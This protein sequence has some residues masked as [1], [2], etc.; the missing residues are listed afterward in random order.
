MS[1]VQNLKMDSDQR[2]HTL[3]LHMFAFTAINLR[4]AVSFFSRVS[5]SNEQLLGLQQFCSNY[6]RATALFLTSTPATWTIGHIVP[7]HAKI[8]HQRLGMGLGKNT[9]EGREAKHVTLAKFTRNAQFSNRFG[10]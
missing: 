8:I 10:G 9:M 3:E 5:L 6:Y 7:S 1:I 2:S 4:D